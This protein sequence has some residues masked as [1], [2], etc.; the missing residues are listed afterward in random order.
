[1]SNNTLEQD[2]TQARQLLDSALARIDHALNQHNIYLLPPRALRLLENAHQN[3]KRQ[4]RVLNSLVP[5]TQNIIQPP[6]PQ[7][8]LPKHLTAPRH[9]AP[10]SQPS[11]KRPPSNSNQKD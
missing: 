5:F 10:I 2:I 6:L 3:I 4:S 11:D 1:M 9:T 7:P 8:I